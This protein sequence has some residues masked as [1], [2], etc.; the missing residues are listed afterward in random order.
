MVPKALALKVGAESS[1]DGDPV[2]AYFYRGPK[3]AY[4][5]LFWP[6]RQ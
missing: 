5:M 2:V 4:L 1:I 6:W 3:I